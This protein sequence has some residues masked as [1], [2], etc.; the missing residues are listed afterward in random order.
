MGGSVLY[1]VFVSPRSG[2]RFLGTNYY[3]G[4]PGEFFGMRLMPEGWCSDE[5]I[6]SADGL[7]LG[8]M[9]VL[10]YNSLS[11]APH[12]PR[13]YTVR[14]YKNGYPRFQC[15]FDL[16]NDGGAWEGLS[17]TRHETIAD[18]IAY[19]RSELG[20]DICLFLEEPMLWY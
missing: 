2:E 1:S 12:I 18:A 17:D 6:I 14:I 3:E 7:S 8:G 9:R 13:L 5:I 15:G 4:Y 11:C 20:E 10:D 19:L 16:L